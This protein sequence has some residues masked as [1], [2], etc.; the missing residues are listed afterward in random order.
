VGWIAQDIESVAPY[1]IRRTRQK[2]RITD[3]A[4]TETLSL[5]TNELPYAVVNC[6]KELLDEREE[7]NREISELRTR[8]EALER[9]SKTTLAD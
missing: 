4:E 3:E 6:L 1:M 2:L 8:L 9:S 7:K 5:N